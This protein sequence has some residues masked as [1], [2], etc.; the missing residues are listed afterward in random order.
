MLI[1][2]IP[3]EEKKRLEELKFS[4]W[5]NIP[6]LWGSRQHLRLLGALTIL[7]PQHQGRA[8]E[9]SVPGIHGRG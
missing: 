9:L 5:D 8:A 1:A 4:L 6:K 2:L 7:S 3:S